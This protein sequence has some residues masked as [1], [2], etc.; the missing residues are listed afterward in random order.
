MI[1]VRVLGGHLWNGGWVLMLTNEVITYPCEMRFR[2]YWQLG[3]G[4]EY[5]PTYVLGA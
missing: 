2:Q 4:L 3:W 5:I 1:E